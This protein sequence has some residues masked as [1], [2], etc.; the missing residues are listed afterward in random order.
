MSNS[1][2]PARGLSLY[3]NLLDPTAATTPGSVARAPVVFKTSTA[4]TLED[5][6]AKKHQIDAGMPSFEC[7]RSVLSANDAQFK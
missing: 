6:S 5:A 7:S 4:D 2:T 3:A 1:S